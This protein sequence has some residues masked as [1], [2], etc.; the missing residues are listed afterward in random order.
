V[1]LTNEA[2]TYYKMMHLIFSV[3]SYPY[4]AT[5]DFANE[6]PLVSSVLLKDFYMEDFPTGTEDIKGTFSLCSQLNSL[7][8]NR[9]CF[10][11]K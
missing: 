3:T 5:N 1:L 7:P 10:L 11:H 8:D 9:Y 4:I 6:F 2:V